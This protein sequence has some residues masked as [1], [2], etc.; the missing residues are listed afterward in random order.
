MSLRTAILI[1]S[2]FGVISDSILIAFYPQFFEARYGV[3]NA[4]H[5]GAYIAAISIAVMC[6]LP[7][8]AYV[9]RY[10][11]TMHLVVYTQFAAGA[12]CLMAIWAPTVQVFWVL[13]MLMYMVKASYLLMFPY[14]MRLEKSQD[15]AVVIGLLTVI[16]YIAGI[17]GAAV[18]GLSLQRLGPDFS[19][20]LMAGGDF[21]QMLLCLYLIC[22]GKVVKV[23]SRDEDNR[24]KVVPKRSREALVKLMQLSLLMLLFD[25]SAYLIRPFFTLYWENTTQIT[26][27]MLTGFV[28]AIPGMV[29]LIALMLKRRWLSPPWW[30]EHSQFNLLLAA[31]GMLMQATPSMWLILLGRCLYGWAIFQ[32]VVKLEVTLFKVSTPESY[33]RDFSVANFFQNFGV[34]LSSFGAGYVVSLLGIPMTFVIA[35]VGMVLTLIFDRSVFELD[36]QQPLK[37]QSDDVTSGEQP[38]LLAAQGGAGHD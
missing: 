21:I 8:W 15:H 24:A 32:L 25:F 37:A 4:V 26:N 17:F 3:T 9:A 38:P 27:Q 29:A 35:A 33:A 23:I 16:V 14:L 5:T 10:V 22:S 7:V 13:T 28:F 19:L 30:V 18:G 31:I 36:R 1:M 12:L 6:M 20:M 11:E 2:A 34:L